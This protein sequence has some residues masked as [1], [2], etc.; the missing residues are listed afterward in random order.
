VISTAGIAEV[1]R[2]GQGRSPPAPTPLPA[3]RRPHDRDHADRA[4]ELLEDAGPDGR[5]KAVDALVIATAA[6]SG[7]PTKVGLHRPFPCPEALPRGFPGAQRPCGTG[8]RPTAA[9][10]RPEA[11]HSMCRNRVGRPGP[12]LTSRT[13]VRLLKRGNA[14]GWAFCRWRRIRRWNAGRALPPGPAFAT[15]MGGRRPPGCGTPRVRGRSRVMVFPVPGQK[16]GRVHPDNRRSP[17]RRGGRGST[18]GRGER[19]RG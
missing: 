6:R 3:H 12:A 10:A 13:P 1:R 2:T 17:G 9:R 5:E 18:S 4:A 7:G 16:R 19:Q 8:P 11:H 15:A 14:I